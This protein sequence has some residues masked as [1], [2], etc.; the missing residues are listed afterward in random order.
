[1]PGYG[2]ST[3]V[4]GGG[5]GGVSGIAYLRNGWVLNEGTSNLNGDVAWYLANTT[6]FDYNESGAAVMLDPDDDSQLLTNNAFGNTNR[7]TNDKGA[8]NYSD[9]G[10]GLTSDGA[11]ANYAV[12]HLTGMGWYLNSVHGGTEHWE[13]T[14]DTIQ[15]FTLTAFDTSTYDDFRMP[16]AMDVTNIQTQEGTGTNVL[17]GIETWTDSFHFIMN[18]S[19]ATTIYFWRELITWF[20]STQWGAFNS[21]TVN[22]GIDGICLRNHY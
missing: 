11:T 16:T 12:D 17:N 20:G 4:L 13:D 21:T 14:R 10:G 8:Q 15:A 6:L 22:A 19:G 3:K 2:I 9:V 5:G 1:M 18:S 7:I